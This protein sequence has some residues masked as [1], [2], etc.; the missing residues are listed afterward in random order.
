MPLQI[1]TSVK[2]ALKEERRN[3]FSERNRGLAPDW[4]IGLEYG[5]RRNDSTIAAYGYSSSSYLLRLRYSYKAPR[6]SN[7]RRAWL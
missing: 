2:A 1:I 3:D 7:G 6:F 4:R 5:L